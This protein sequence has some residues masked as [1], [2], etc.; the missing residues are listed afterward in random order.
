[1]LSNERVFSTAL[2]LLSGLFLTHFSH[3]SLYFKSFL[4]SQY[5]GNAKCLEGAIK[6]V[7]F[8]LPGGNP[9]PQ[10]TVKIGM[11]SLPKLYIPRITSEFQFPLLFI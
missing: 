3:S 11:T 10:L 2:M 1:M 4:V 7:S 9:I 5:L 6:H 8:S